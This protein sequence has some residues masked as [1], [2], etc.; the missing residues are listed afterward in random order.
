ML[1]EWT[2]KI[3]FSFKLRYIIIQEPLALVIT[4]RTRLGTD[5]APS[6]GLPQQ[7]QPSL[8]KP[9]ENHMQ[10]VQEES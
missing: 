8:S 1:F 7:A 5:N 3:V 10:F 4:T 9:P 2:K 6:L